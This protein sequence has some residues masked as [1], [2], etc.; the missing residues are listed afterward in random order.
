MFGSLFLNVAQ[1]HEAAMAG[2][3]VMISAATVVQLRTMQMA[4]GAMAPAEA[5]RMIVEKPSAFA[6]ASENYLRALASNRGYAAATLAGL[7]PYQSATS[8]NA[9]RLSGL[10]AQEA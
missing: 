10:D 6:S 8:A 1:W 9:K 3:E 7:A 2:T 5:A 4:T